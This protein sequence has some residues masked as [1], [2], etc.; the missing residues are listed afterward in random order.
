M[1]LT[2]HQK[3]TNPSNMLI[4]HMNHN[5][6]SAFASFAEGLFRKRAWQQDTD[7]IFSTMMLHGRAKAASY[8]SYESRILS[9]YPPFKQN[10]ETHA[11]LQS[12]RTLNW[13]KHNRHPHDRPWH[14]AL[15]HWAFTANGLQ[16]IKNLTQ[17]LDWPQCGGFRRLLRSLWG[18]NLAWIWQHRTRSWDCYW[19]SSRRRHAPHRLF[20]LSLAADWDIPES[21][22]RN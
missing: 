20:F 4:D 7:I 11:G 21:Y 16:S 8:T 22:S 6:P 10:D 14:A 1:V 17:F 9:V 12:R 2:E 19:N 15:P 18:F 5:H 13:S 3:T